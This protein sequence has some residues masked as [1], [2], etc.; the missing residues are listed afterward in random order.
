MLNVNGKD[1]ILVIKEEKS[2][3]GGRPQPLPEDMG[4][5]PEPEVME[6]PPPEEPPPE[7]PARRKRRREH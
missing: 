3:S 4:E 5:M 6:E 1:E 7:E 2:K